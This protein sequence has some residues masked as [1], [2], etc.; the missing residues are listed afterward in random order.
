M[1]TVLLTQPN[2]PCLNKHTPRINLIKG[3]LSMIN[4]KD[5]LTYEVISKEKNS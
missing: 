2:V 5:N 3:N 4:D 1:G